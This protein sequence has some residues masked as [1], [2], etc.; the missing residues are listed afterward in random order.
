MKWWDHHPVP[1]MQNNS[2]KLLW[3]F[4]IQTD[5]RLSHNRPDIVCVDFIKKQC[6]LIDV[7]ILGDSHL[8][9][10]VTE[11]NKNILTLN[12]KYRKCGR[13]KLL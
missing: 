1:V 13:Q 6:F 9:N 10:K 5:R 8:T 7:A 11:N 4:T 12:L 3:D 2:M